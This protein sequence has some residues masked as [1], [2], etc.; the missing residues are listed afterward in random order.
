MKVVVAAL[1]QEASRGREETTRNLYDLVWQGVRDKV[2][3]PRTLSC[4]VQP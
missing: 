1:E 3:A 4:L 2:G